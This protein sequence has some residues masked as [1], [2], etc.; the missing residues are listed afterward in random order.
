MFFWSQIL[1]GHT[2]ERRAQRFSIKNY[3]ECIDGQPFTYAN[4]LSRFDDVND[5][6]WCNENPEAFK[7]DLFSLDLV[8]NWYSE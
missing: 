2:G 5:Q 7:T 3:I 1:R 8:L 4:E 6:E